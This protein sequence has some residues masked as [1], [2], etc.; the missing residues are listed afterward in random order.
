MADTKVKDIAN[1]TGA[2]PGWIE[3]PKA[4]LG[5]VREFLHD[6]RMELR[7][8]TWPSWNDVRA[9]TVVVIVTVF[10][11]GLYFWIVDNGVQRVVQLIFDKFKP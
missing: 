2:L 1:A 10:F 8:V 3:K 9:T 4:R 7:Q 11:F 6:V 5:R